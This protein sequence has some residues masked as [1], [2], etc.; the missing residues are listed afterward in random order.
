MHS[1]NDGNQ[2]MEN[3]PSVLKAIVLASRPKTW[4]AGISPVAIGAALA[5]RDGPCSIHLFL[6][7]IFFSLFIQIGTNFSNDYYD[8]ING[9]DN[10]KR[11][12][13]A[14]AVAKGWIE[15]ETMRNA[16][17]FLFGAAFLVSLPLVFACG[18][19]AFLFVLSA[20][21]F[22]ILYTG[23]PLPLGYMGLGELLVLI[24]FG[25]VAVL[26]TYYVQRQALT[27]DTCLLSLVPGFLSAAI[28]VANNLRD[29][30]TDRE[31]GK[32][33]LVVQWGRL[34]GR[35]EYAACMVLSALI[36][37]FFGYSLSFFVFL[38]SIPLIRSAFTYTYPEEIV[39]LLPKTALH[40]ILF[41]ILFCLEAVL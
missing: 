37:Y 31:T 5:F 23:G 10:H 18:L 12:G 13:P 15:P 9:A 17:L 22:G 36:L 41:T 6:C 1:S 16:S 29:E 20:I 7:S 8:F 24:F 33:T 19:W 35:I 32:R 27:F 38:A 3:S 25:P 4:I 21:A 2:I 14:R 40:L 34:F 11:I 28:L 26:G 30:Y 39:T